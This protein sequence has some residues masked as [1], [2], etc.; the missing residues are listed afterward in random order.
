LPFFASRGRERG[1]LGEER[2]AEALACFGFGATVFLG[3]AFGDPAAFL[4]LGADDRLDLAPAAE[5]RADFL[6]A[7]FGLAAVL[8]PAVRFTDFFFAAF[9]LA[10]FLAAFAIIHPRQSFHP[11]VLA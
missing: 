5:L 1:A 6:L 3:V 2:G 4:A 11:I 7:A 10:F 9:V 8:R